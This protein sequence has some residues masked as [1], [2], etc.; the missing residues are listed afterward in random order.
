MTDVPDDADD[1]RD[2]IMTE[3]TKC[4][5][6]GNGGGCGGGR[7][8][9]LPEFDCSFWLWLLAGLLSWLLAVGCSACYL[10]RGG[11]ISIRIRSYRQGP[12]C[13]LSPVEPSSVG[14][15]LVH[16]E[17]TH[18]GHEKSVHRKPQPQHH[19]ILHLVLLARASVSD[20]EYVPPS[21]AFE[22]CSL[23]S[24][25]RLSHSSTHSSPPNSFRGGAGH[26]ATVAT[27]FG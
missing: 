8:G 25:R 9:C 23:L 5:G 19:S 10:L 13:S 2:A 7:G 22:A 18:N 14:D 3:M 17:A 26:D 21:L 6:S 24:V 1:A 15:A 11:C 4:S 12:H 16:G 20:G 27:H